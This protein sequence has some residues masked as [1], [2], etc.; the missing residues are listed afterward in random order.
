MTVRM[1]LFNRLRVALSL[2]SVIADLDVGAGTALVVL[3]EPIPMT[4]KIERLFG[5][6]NS[7]VFRLCGRVQVEHVSTISDLILG[8]TGA[9]ALDFEEVTLV[10][11]DVISFLVVCELKGIELRNSPAFLQEWVAQ[12]KARLTGEPPINAT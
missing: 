4:C 9:I 10:D 8:E 12:E 7:V 11:R 5:A 3:E 6:E 1:F 2:L